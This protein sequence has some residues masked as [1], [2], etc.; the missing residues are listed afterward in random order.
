MVLPRC[1]AFV[2]SSQPYQKLFTIQHPLLS[3]PMGTVLL[4][5]MPGN[6]WMTKHTSH[7]CGH[8]LRM[9]E[10]HCH[11]MVTCGNC[12]KSSSRSSQDQ[13]T[14]R[15]RTHLK[16]QVPSHLNISVERFLIHFLVSLVIQDRAKIFYK[17]VL[18]CITASAS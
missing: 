17:S 10:G 15:A 7:V 2:L 18:Y 13:S 12:S 14:F 6:V 8:T 4:A 1:L 11:L 5:R 9:K 3:Q 16:H